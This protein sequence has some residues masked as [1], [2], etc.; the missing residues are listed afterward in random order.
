MQVMQKS[1]M[2]SKDEMGQ[3]AE[4]VRVS[5]QLPKLPEW[6]PETAPIDFGDWLTCLEVHMADLSSS[7]EQWWSLV[8]QTVTE[9]YSDH[10]SLTP[11]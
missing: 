11:I 8:M 7:S 3:E 2:Q 6:C 9:W 1:M 10:M 5:P 4:E